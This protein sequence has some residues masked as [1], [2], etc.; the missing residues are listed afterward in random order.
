MTAICTFDITMEEAWQEIVLDTPVNAK[1][2]RV[3]L[4]ENFCKKDDSFILWIEMSEI[5]IY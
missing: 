4:V 5:K 2:V 3:E 1:F